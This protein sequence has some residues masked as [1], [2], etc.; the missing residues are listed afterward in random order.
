[1][2]LTAEEILTLRKRL[3]GNALRPKKGKHSGNTMA[4]FTEDVPMDRDLPDEQFLQEQD[5]FRAEA[6]MKQEKIITHKD[7]EARME[8]NF[9]ETFLAT[10]DEYSG[11]VQ[12][13]GKLLK[14]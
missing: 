9:M 6:A 5:M 3:E 2:E 11:K 12:V 14:C 4:G 1:M 8:D 13:R 7:M 10:A